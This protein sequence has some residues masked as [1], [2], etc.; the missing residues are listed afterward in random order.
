MMQA[1]E[2]DSGSMIYIWHSKT[3]GYAIQIMSMLVL[4]LFERLMGGIYKVCHYNGIRWH[5]IHD[6][7]FRH[8]NNI[9]VITSTIWKAA[10][11]ILLTGGIYEVHI[12]DSLTRHYIHIMFHKDHE[13]QVFRVVKE[14]TVCTHIQVHTFYQFSK[15]INIVLSVHC[16]LP[17]TER[18]ASH[19]SVAMPC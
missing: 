3:N 16:M 7:W 5:D 9:K 14:H 10:I 11:L 12:W 8:S 6:K 19:H 13:V 2:M 15:L 17:C 18:C 1:V 4:Q